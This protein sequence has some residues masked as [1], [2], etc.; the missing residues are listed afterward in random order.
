ML[1]CIETSTSVCSVA[2]TDKGKLISFREINEGFSHT[3][4]LTVFISEVLNEA[5]I[6]VKDLLTIAVSSGP[7]SYTGLRI[8]V[9]VAK[10]LCLAIDKP[11]ISISTLESMSWG[12]KNKIN[13]NDSDILFCPMIDARRMEVYSALY[14]LQLKCLHPSSAIILSEDFFAEESKGKKVYYFGNGAEKCRTIL[15][16]HNEFIFYPEIYPSAKFMS[17]LALDKF[18]NKQFENLS[19]F[20]P[21]YLKEYQAGRK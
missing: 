20:E 13:K 19:L 7:G 4:K 5:G 3:E 8:G 1:L 12:A 17:V 16:N 18:I 9:S 10:G 11:L 15:N 2:L 6:T 21:F 14:D